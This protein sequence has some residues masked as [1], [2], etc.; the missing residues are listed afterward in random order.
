MITV[1]IDPKLQKFIS[2][3]KYT[4]SFVFNTLGY[5]MRFVSKKE[6]LA[7][8]DI[9][10]YYSDKKPT[11]EEACHW[12]MHRA[13]FYV[14]V[15][16]ELLNPRLLDKKELRNLVQEIKL[17]QLVPIISKENVKIP[18]KYFKHKMIF[19]GIYEFDIIGNF[20]FN[21]IDYDELNNPVKDEFG[22][23]KE[24]E[25][26]F[27]NNQE[28]PFVNQLLWMVD[29][30]I[31]DAVKNNDSL[32]L[33]RKDFWQ[34]GKPFAAVF[35]HT[36]YS[37]QKW[38]L[39]KIF[40]S[41]F[42]EFLKFWH[43]KYN[44]KS[45]FDKMKFLFTNIEE[46]WKFDDIREIENQHGVNSTYFF[47][48]T[49]GNE[50]DYSLGDEDLQNEISALQKEYNEISLLASNNSSRDDILESEKD[51]LKKII[52]LEEVGIRHYLNKFNPQFTIEYHKKHG[53]IY[54]SSR[55][56]LKNFGFVNG[57]GFPYY[58][59]QLLVPTQQNV[60]QFQSRYIELPI[61]FS[62]RNLRISK[63]KT[64][65]FEEAKTIV[66]NLI[67]TIIKTN[68]F[69]HFDFSISS[70]SEIKYGQQ[71]YNYIIQKVKE[72]NGFIGNCMQITNWWKKRERV[73]I[74]ENEIGALIQ[75]PENIDNFTLELLGNYNV[76]KVDG[77]KSAIDGPKI[78]FNNI[79]AGTKVQIFIG[80]IE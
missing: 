79:L 30:A 68:G 36:V 12:A 38:N 22:R 17:Q 69:I 15:Q 34:N 53:F 48:A 66:N 33:L 25:L 73:E 50:I 67:E 80:K 57:M 2:E 54:D 62:D 4:F 8:N 29:L 1:Y 41:S 9:L 77:A 40:K 27:I 61:T 42:V 74:I 63:Y 21:L 52:N 23:S 3:I 55:T 71:I 49:N 19:F 35:S 10:F 32:F 72:H 43:F 37:L 46:Y 26:I 45:F 78:I 59:H 28:A 5:E 7:N 58:V 56:F 20:F 31:K 16:K 75:F 6:Q 11:I 60:P 64:L 51:N 13:I 39:H 44:V 14:P 24:N 70:F 18:I 76:E 65:P 47:Y